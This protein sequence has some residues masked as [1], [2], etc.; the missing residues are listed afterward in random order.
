MA[1]PSVRVVSTD[2]LDKTIT[3]LVNGI[4]VE[5]FIKYDLYDRAVRQLKNSIA[6]GWCNKAITDL[7]VAS[8]HT[9]DEFGKRIYGNPNWVKKGLPMSQRNVP[10]PAE[11]SKIPTPEY[12]FTLIAPEAQHGLVYQ[13]ERIWHKT[14][15]AAVEYAKTIYNA[16]KDQVFSLVVVKAS[17][18]IAPK[19]QI[20]LTSRTF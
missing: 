6:E 3:L 7:F 16:N 11:Y 12:P 2:D 14:E 9:K 5:F 13:G 8:L 1:Q 15:D 10:K 4:R 19:P 18:E 20:E 17:Q